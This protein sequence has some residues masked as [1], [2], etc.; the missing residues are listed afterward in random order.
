MSARPYSA[1]RTTAQSPQERD[2]AAQRSAVEFDES[3]NE[4]AA[5]RERI[6]VAAYYIAERRG[7]APGVEMEDWLAAEAALEG[8]GK[9]PIP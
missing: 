5:R 6:A 4:E 7:F 9:S 2:K 1:K 3:V 8:S